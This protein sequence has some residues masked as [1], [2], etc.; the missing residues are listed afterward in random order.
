MLSA[1][2]RYLDAPDLGK[3]I[4]RVS[5]AAMMF[6]HG[7]HKVTHGIDGIFK[8]LTAHGLPEFIGYGVYLGEVLAPILLI[9]GILTR[10][11]ALLMLGTM[12]FAWLLAGT[13]QTFTLTKVG[14]WGIEHM[15]VYFFASLAIL[16]LGSG[17]YSVVSNPNLR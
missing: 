10:P 5:F 9:L 13:E 17:R 12:V 3:L 8:M 14:A 15:M 2:N 6:L 1:F 4:L 16:F 11:S 7:W